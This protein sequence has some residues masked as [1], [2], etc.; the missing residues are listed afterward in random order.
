MFILGQITLTKPGC[1]CNVEKEVNQ[2]NQLN[3]KMCPIFCLVLYLD[4][5]SGCF[6]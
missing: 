3:E 1:V 4:E 5:S 6:Q 2:E